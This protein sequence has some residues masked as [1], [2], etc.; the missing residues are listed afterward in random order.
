MI[1]RK[2]KYSIQNRI[3]AILI[4]IL[5]PVGVCL[6]TISAYTR[7]KLRQEV[8]LSNL[9][10]LDRQVE[11]LNQQLRSEWN[12]LANTFAVDDRMRQLKE[13]P[14]REDRVNLIYQVKQK[15][16]NFQAEGGM[17]EFYF[18]LMEDDR[19]SA[20]S[21]R[22]NYAWEDK[23]MAEKFMN[24]WDWQQSGNKKFQ[25][26]FDIGDSWYFLQAFSDG[27]VCLGEMMRLDTLLGSL[28]MR[29]GEGEKISFVDK[30]GKFLLDNAWIDSRA[31]TY[32]ESNDNVFIRTGNH[33]AYDLLS[34]D[35]GY[36]PGAV[37]YIVNDGTI[38]GNLTQITSLLTG[39]ALAMVLLIPI[40]LV[41]FHSALV[42]PL[43]RLKDTIVRIKE[44]QMVEKVIYENASAEMAEVYDL[45]N[46]MIDEIH[47]LKILSYEEEIKKKDYQLQYFALQLKP[48]F[49]L[50]SL[51]C[52]YAL[53][54]KEEY[55][56][57]QDM[58]LNLSDYFKSMT[59]DN[60]ST[61]TV[62]QELEHVSIYMDIRQMGV[63]NVIDCRLSLDSR[64]RQ[65]LIPVR[66]IQT[67]VENSVKY[68]MVCGQ[69]LVIDIS[70]NVLETKLKRYVDIIV[71]DN[72]KGYPANVLATINKEN[73]DNIDGHIGL[74]NLWNRLKI[75]Y[76]GE[77]FMTISNRPEG[78]AYSEVLLPVDSPWKAVPVRAFTEVY[79]NQEGSM[80]EHFSRG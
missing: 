37:V 32:S 27:Q 36:L 79:K 8:A 11:N 6:M 73:V 14:R 70:V 23:V 5:V 80:D 61:A 12:F 64:A 74:T 26:L 52:L 60:Q 68:G 48:H 35:G 1:H 58:I 9:A 20:Y 49:Y 25:E 75:M 16:A 47:H 41:A 21:Y 55:R 18:L 45:F 17:G 71:T 77:A 15:F 13:D 19:Y 50:N 22:G 46:E 54:Q 44:G 4:L 78:G 38:L 33:K 40:S 24:A 30:T 67:F 72:G 53:A 63:E 69:E 31:I 62:I 2:K 76:G 7:H 10:I 28:N 43:N 59:Y 39:I 66:C 57:V 42:V 56:K 65:E 34:C 51:K 3:F 29:N